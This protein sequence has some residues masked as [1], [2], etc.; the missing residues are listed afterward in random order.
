MKKINGEKILIKL[1]LS[2]NKAKQHG[3]NLEEIIKEEIMELKKEKYS[4]RDILEIK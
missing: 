3:K 2:T 1:G 4:K